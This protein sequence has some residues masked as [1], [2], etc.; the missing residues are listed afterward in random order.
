[1]E[2][3]DHESARNALETMNGRRVFDQVDCLLSVKKMTCKEQ[4]NLV[5]RMKSFSCRL[6]YLKNLF[7]CILLKGQ[8]GFLG[9][10]F[11]QKGV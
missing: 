11:C 6:E 9:Q 10:A 3:E 1:M 8:A 4:P 5:P 7:I 2:F